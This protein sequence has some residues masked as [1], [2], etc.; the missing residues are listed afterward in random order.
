MVMAFALNSTNSCVLQAF[1]KAVK[2]A[3]GSLDGASFEMLPV[4]I[5]IAK[6][7][8]KGLMRKAD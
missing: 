4:E 1:P 8:G 5:R 6:P 7:G 3:A 2:F